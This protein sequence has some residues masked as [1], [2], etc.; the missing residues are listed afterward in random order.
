MK[1]SSAASFCLLSAQANAFSSQDSRI[2]RFA[3][4]S[5]AELRMGKSNT[6]FDNF[7]SPIVSALNS[8][9][10]AEPCL[11]EAVESTINKENTNSY[12]DDGFV[13]GLEGS[14]LKRP[15]GKVAQVVVEGDSLETQSHQVALVSATF[16]S[17]SL[18][19]V[20]AIA[21]SGAIN[22]GDIPLT[23]AQ[24]VAT[25][26]STWL[27]A[28]LGSGILHWSVDNYGNGRTPIMGGIIAAFQGHH[29]AQWTIT[30]RGFFNNV[31]KLC[32]PFGIPTVAAI[33]L[34]AGP[35]HPMVSL[36]F[37]SFCA[38]EILSQE[39]HKWSHMTKTQLNP[40]ILAL[41]NYGVTVD[42]IS[43]ANHHVAP[44]DGN[45]CIVS[46][47]WNKMLDQSGVLRRIE[48]IIY[49]HNGVESN[50]WKLDA[51]LRA[52]TLSGDFSL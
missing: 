48:K 44:Y 4:T 32:I 13:F 14:G 19:A 36:F 30:E 18:F 15:R 3:F 40:F 10:I 21:Q 2:K 27:L 16:A 52:K 25:L 38:L 47:F 33:S 12:L 49:D 23:I 20:N 6:S 37:T 39:F 46:G 11:Q 8:A 17:H 43:H 5:Q 31:S 26:L 7:S 22:N 24:T 45:Y 1:F 50:A 29:S 51:K 9:S 34:L 42:R 41:Q 35:S 28:D